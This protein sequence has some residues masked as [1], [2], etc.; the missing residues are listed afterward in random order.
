MIIGA[1]FILDMLFSLK[2]G[3]KSKRQGGVSPVSTDVDNVARLIRKKLLINP[4]HDLGQCHGK[5]V[6]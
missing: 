3:H 4:S 2:P 6:C 1:T 5:G